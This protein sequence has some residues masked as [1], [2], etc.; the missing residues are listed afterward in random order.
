MRRV[1]ALLRGTWR[2]LGILTLMVL[3]VGMALAVMVAPGRLQAER[4]CGWWMRQLLALLGVRVQLSGA[5]PAAPEGLL[6]ANHVSWLD[7]AVIASLLPGRFVAKRELRDWPLLGSLAEAA[8]TYFIRRGGHATQALSERLE[9]QLRGG[10]R[11]LLFPE[12]TTTRGTSLRRFHPRLFAAAAAGSATIQ[13]LALRYGRA[14]DG[15]DLAPFVDEDSLLPHLLRLLGIPGLEVHV[16]LAPAF[17]AVGSRSALARRAQAAVA[18]AL[19]EGDT[20]E[21]AGYRQAQLGETATALPTEAA[22]LQ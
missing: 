12:G 7:I 4:L 21:P 19:A 20:A 16:V 14:P 6:V 18:G 13:P 17:V 9:C 11:V 2:T 5:T 22:Q 8:G 3:A 10:G 1:A 15:R